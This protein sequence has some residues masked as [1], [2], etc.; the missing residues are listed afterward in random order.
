VTPAG[1]LGGREPLRAPAAGIVL[2]AC[3]TQ[4]VRHGLRVLIVEDDALQAK[5]LEP[6]LTARGYSVCAIV[7]TAEEALFFAKGKKPDIVLMDVRLQ[8]HLDGIDA[9]ALISKTCDCGIV[10]V[11]GHADPETKLRIRRIT[12]AAVTVV[13]PAS[14]PL[15]ADAI[16]RAMSGR[17]AN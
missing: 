5:A 15:I 11:T 7:K 14:G 4:G 8:G 12:P 2:P 1:R 16:N 17:A 6:V 3:T 10:F 13:K 9:A